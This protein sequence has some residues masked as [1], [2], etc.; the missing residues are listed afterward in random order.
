MWALPQC[1]KKD[2]QLSRISTKEAQWDRK[3]LC[4]KMLVASVECIYF[5]SSGR[6]KKHNW[7]IN[8]CLYEKWIMGN[9]YTDCVH[10]LLLR[11]LSWHRKKY[12]HMYKCKGWRIR[13]DGF[14]KQGCAFSRSFIT[15]LILL[16]KSAE[17]AA[18]F[19]KL[20]Q[21]ELKV[22]SRYRVQRL[23]ESGIF[24]LYANACFQSVV[25]LGCITL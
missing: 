17:V 22:F 1:R 16:V 12:I 5:H 14:C 15:L 2:K 18:C 13:M 9:I 3:I 6:K 25:F 21:T 19:S 4:L 7:F 20:F 11:L 8:I 24:I 23:S 10:L